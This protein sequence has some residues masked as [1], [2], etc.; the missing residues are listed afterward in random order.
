MKR[1]RSGLLDLAELMAG[2]QQRGGRKRDTVATEAVN[3]IKVMSVCEY[4]NPG[5]T[6]RLYM[7]H[8]RFAPPPARCPQC[9]REVITDPTMVVRPWCYWE[10]VK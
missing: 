9:F 4:I 8:Y 6:T 1:G 3:Q 2:T 10:E 5:R 7:S